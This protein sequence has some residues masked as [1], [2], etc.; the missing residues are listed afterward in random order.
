MFMSCPANGVVGERVVSRGMA[1]PFFAPLLG[2]CVERGEQPHGL[3]VESEQDGEAKVL[4]VERPGAQRLRNGPTPRRQ[5]ELAEAGS[6]GKQQ[7]FWLWAPPPA[8]APNG[9]CVCA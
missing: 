2:P 1:G 5:H 9:C 8:G 6:K 7:G 3:L 4:T